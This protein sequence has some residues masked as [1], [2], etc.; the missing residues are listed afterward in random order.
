MMFDSESRERDSK[1]H[2]DARNYPRTK[3]MRYQNIRKRIYPNGVTPEC[4]IGG[5]VPAS[6]GIPIEAFGNDRL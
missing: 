2:S 1:I 6:P 4:L 3:L 5:P